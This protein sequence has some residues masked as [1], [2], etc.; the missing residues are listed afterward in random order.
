MQDLLHVLTQWPATRRGADVR[1][2]AASSG[3]SGARVWRVAVDE[4]AFA[5]RC[6]QPHVRTD[7][8]SVIHAFQAVQG[9]YGPPVIP[10]LQW[11]VDRT[12]IAVVNGR[13]WELATWR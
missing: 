4:Q 9:S 12:T 2:V 10:L 7:Q 13:L 3:L 11:T 8:L 6:W 5:L 1:P